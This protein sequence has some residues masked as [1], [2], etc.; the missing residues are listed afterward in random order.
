MSSSSSY[1]GPVSLSLKN[2]TPK[3]KTTGISRQGVKLFSAS[4]ADFEES[5][6]RSSQRAES[7]SSETK[8]SIRSS[9]SNLVKCI[10]GPGC[11]ALPGGIA[12][13]ANSPSVILPALSLMFVIGA[14]SAYGYQLIGRTCFHEGASSYKDA[15]AK[16]VSPKT[17]WIPGLSSLVTTFGS[18]VAFGIVLAD[19]LPQVSAS[20]LNI[21]IARSHALLG[22]SATTILPLCLM[23]SMSALAPFSL[24][25][26]L[27]MVF[28]ALAIGTR[29]FDGSYRAGGH[30]FS[31]IATK[32]FFGSQSSVFNARVF[33]FI[34]MISKSFMAHYTAPTMYRS[35]ENN[36][37]KRFTKMVAISYA[38]AFVIM[39]AVA[40]MAYMTFGG[41]SAQFVLTN[42]AMQD[43]LMSF[44]NVAIVFA[45]LF[46]YPLTFVGFRDD[47]LDFMG[48]RNQ[49]KQHQ[50]DLFTVGLLI[51]STSLSLT[52]KNIGPVMSLQG[53]T[54]GNLLT[55]IYPTFMFWRVAKKKPQLR[56]EV[57]AVLTTGLLG[58][59]MAII[60]TSEAIKAL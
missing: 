46:A 33:I 36:T 58:I 43:T 32:P 22:I 56:K 29:F 35:L 15:W 37:E 59:V 24:V 17:A 41:A 28:S 18:V 40:A 10:V 31:H 8:A 12:A 44:V 55:F 21:H 50:K 9:V 42:Y 34:S 14:M 48:I 23:R 51:L 39:A 49:C 20:F 60:G 52:F 45:I 11:L 57:P 25:G 7:S 30:F 5:K 6:S 53:A 13:F 16:A 19:M 54:V 47:V 27:G 2:P 1:V 4:A 38:T 3:K 26:S